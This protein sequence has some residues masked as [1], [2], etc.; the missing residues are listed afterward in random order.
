M[1]QRLPKA[2]NYELKELAKKF[3]IG[4]PED[5]ENNSVGASK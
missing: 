5:W 3:L 4:W 1:K 2:D